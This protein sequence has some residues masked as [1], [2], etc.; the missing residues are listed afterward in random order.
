MEKGRRA[1][2]LTID[3]PLPSS[4]MLTSFTSTMTSIGAIDAG[5]AASDSMVVFCI[6]EGI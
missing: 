5:A 2:Y 3:S 1:D 6:T 4:S